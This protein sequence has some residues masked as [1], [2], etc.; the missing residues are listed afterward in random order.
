MF[1]VPAVFGALGVAAG[2]VAIVKD[3]RWRGALVV[4]LNASGAFVGY[5]WASVI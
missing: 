3:A 5:H 1:L 4:T 2:M